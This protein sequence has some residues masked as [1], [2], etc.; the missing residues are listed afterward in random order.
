M[1]LS[2]YK[3]LVGT[4][5]SYAQIAQMLS[6]SLMCWEFHRNGTTRPTPATM[7][8]MGGALGF[9]ML[10]FARIM[11]DPAMLR[12][13]WVGMVL[14]QVYLLCYWLYSDDRPG[15]YR[16][17]AKGAALAGGL[18]AYARL[19][20]PELVEHRF[21]IILTGLFFFMVS[22]PLFSVGEIIRTKSSASIPLPMLLTGTV[23]SSLWLLYGFI[24]DS[25]FMI[26]Q[27]VVVLILSAFQFALILI[28]PRTLPPHETKKVD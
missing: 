6:G 27:N 8:V 11:D 22:L 9:V 14:S 21:G 13:N 15:F 26:F 19:E 24:I 12:A 16:S 17:L 28:Y 1:P 2:D 10:E 4:L 7:F 20:D 25:G 23:V 3:D 5:A 18:V